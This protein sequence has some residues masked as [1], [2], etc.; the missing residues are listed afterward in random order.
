MQN[1]QKKR[2]SVGGVVLNIKGQVLVVSQHGN[3]WSLP[4]GGIN[5]GEDPKTCL[6]REMEEETGI[7][8]FK[9]IKYLGSYERYRISKDTKGDDKS[10]LK[11]F[12]IFL[13]KTNET[14]LEPSDPHNPEARWVDKDKVAD[15]LTHPKDKEFFKSVSNKIDYEIG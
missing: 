12:I 15:L 7:K 10:L 3:S 11:K 6:H 9:I 5:E 1:K 2:I 14:K 8:N 4:K 13:C